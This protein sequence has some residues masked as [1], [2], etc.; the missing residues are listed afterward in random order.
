[1][2]GILNL[3][4]F[5]ATSSWGYKSSLSDIKLQQSKWQIVIGRREITAAEKKDGFSIS[6]F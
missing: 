4:A 1:M 6:L 3:N 2:T 5:P